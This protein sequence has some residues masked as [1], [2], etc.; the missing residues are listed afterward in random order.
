VFSPDG[1]RIL[2]ISTDR[3]ARLWDAASGREL[4]RVVHDGV[5]AAAVFTPDGRQAVTGSRDGTVKSFRTDDRVLLRT[6]VHQI[7][8]LALDSHGEMLLAANPDGTISVFDAG[9]G[10]LACNIKRGR[11]VYAIALS[12]DRRRILSVVFGDLVMMSA[13]G[14]HVLWSRSIKNS[15]EESVAFDGVGKLVAVG[16][17]NHAILVLDAQSGK[18]VWVSEAS[19][20]VRAI[21]L[22]RDG[23]YLAV[24]NDDGIAAVY[25][26]AKRKEI[27]HIS[28]MDEV[29]VA[30]FSPDGRLAFFG[31]KSRV[32]KM[33]SLRSG[34][35]IDMPQDDEILA[36]AFSDDGRSI[37][38]GSVD[39][40]ARVFDVE[41]AQE[42]VRATLGGPVVSVRFWAGGRE[43][44][45]ASFVLLP[46]EY[47][48]TKTKWM[49]YRQSSMSIAFFCEQ[50]I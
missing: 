40:T 50:K 21:A 20:R 22:S 42:I 9:T 36:A 6:E 27:I 44:R 41:S 1:L 30:A 48:A 13:N 45:A 35:S 25:D 43:L 17:D 37:A 2:T 23:R 31:G 49:R 24:G 33:L 28:F 16:N 39:H 15:D 7:Q 46:Q 12:P 3:M 4:L 32:A 19:R 5:V 38:T 47:A 26:V 10:T 34:D 14:A 29:T 11:S 8:G 18:D